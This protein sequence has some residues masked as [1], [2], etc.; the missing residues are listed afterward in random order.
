MCRPG[1]TVT[2][3]RSNRRY[4][5]HHSRSRTLPYRG[6]GDSD[7]ALLRGSNCCCWSCATTGGVRTLDRN[8][9]AVN[10]RRI[11]SGPSAVASIVCSE[12]L[13]M[14][15]SV[16]DRVQQ[17]RSPATKGRVCVL[18]INHT[19]EGRCIAPA[20]ESVAI[21]VRFDS[22]R[23]DSRG[24]AVLSSLQRARMCGYVGRGARDKL[25]TGLP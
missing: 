19:E 11:I 9:D 21:E 15:R 8:C 16:L 2:P 5:R 4:D 17:K 14:S 10:V 1:N 22:D 23:L 7:I 6:R 18:P 13:A 12:Q 24:V 25:A 3:L 20:G